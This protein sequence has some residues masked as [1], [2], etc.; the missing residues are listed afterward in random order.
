MTAQEGDGALQ[1]QAATRILVA[2]AR[3]VAHGSD[4]GSGLDELLAVTAEAVGAAS[5]AVV[6]PGPGGALEILAT[7]GLDDGARAGLAAACQNPDHPIART[8]VDREPTFNVLP[9]RPAG[10][11]LRS[12]LP[13]TVDRAG[14]D[15][16]VG[17]LALAHERPIEPETRPVLLAAADL[18]AAAIHRFRAV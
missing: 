7:Y 11:A 10:P 9:T 3:V 13:L 5:A 12:H 1:E 4:L 17:V 15:V 8:F 14:G 18:A 2:G 16:V 6:V